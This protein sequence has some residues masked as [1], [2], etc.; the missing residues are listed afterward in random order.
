M[1][2]AGRRRAL[3][4]TYKGRSNYV[5]A[6]G[7]Q[8]NWTC[9]ISRRAAVK[10]QRHAISGRNQTAGNL[11]LSQTALV[12][13]GPD[14]K[15]WKLPNTWIIALYVSRPGVCSSLIRCRGRAPPVICPPQAWLVH[16]FWL[17][18]QRGFIHIGPPVPGLGLVPNCKS[19]PIMG[20]PMLACHQETHVLPYIT[21]DLRL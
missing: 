9:P 4:S 11:L 2:A 10:Q 13:H 7:C 12:S 20:I 19:Y 21:R 16:L 1:D 14:F 5:L 6:G 18:H 8:R 17:L 15:G 3:E